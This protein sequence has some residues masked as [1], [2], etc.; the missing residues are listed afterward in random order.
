MRLDDFRAR[1]S[2]RTA[3]R[4]SNPR[5]KRLV[6]QQQ[7]NA[8]RMAYLQ[9]M[10]PLL[11]RMN[12]LTQTR[13]VP[14]LPALVTAAG[15]VH[16]A[17]SLAGYW[18]KVSRTVAEM[19]KALFD[20]FPLSKLQAMA[21]KFGKRTSQH[22]RL[23]LARQ[24][25]G[26]ISIDVEKSEP[27]LKPRLAAWAH[28]NAQK[29]KSVPAR[30]LVEIEQRT[31]Q[32][33]RTGERAEDIAKVYAER[34]GV[35]QSRAA[36]IARD[37]IGKLNGRL[38]IAR[39]KDAGI[40]QYTWRTSEDERVRPEHEAVDGK[41]FGIDDAPSFGAPGEDFECRCMA[42]PN[43]QSAIDALADL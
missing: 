15:I 6:K 34:Y 16:D 22:Q 38:N 26:S 10:Q 1:V 27:W 21:A 17:E 39:Q 36:F 20:E 29:I 5:I 25:R 18:S 23:E 43:V 2:A 14:Q 31:L 41:V 32:A 28:E 13:L 40:A 30:Y 7:P 37:Q 9:A 8:I 24:L 42:E 35:S 19:G 11:E 4:T 12:E 3:F 33:L